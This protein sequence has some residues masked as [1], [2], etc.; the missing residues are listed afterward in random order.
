[1]LNPERTA[2]AEVTSDHINFG[3]EDVC[4]SYTFSDNA[5]E[6]FARIAQH[7]EAYLCIFS[8]SVEVL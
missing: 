6:T 3:L 2:S 8:L 4:V 5:A 1:M 7:S